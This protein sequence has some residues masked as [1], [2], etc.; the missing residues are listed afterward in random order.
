[1]LRLPCAPNAFAA[2]LAGVTGDASAADRQGLA[3]GPCEVS[4]PYTGGLSSRL[5][6]S[7]S[8]FFCVFFSHLKHTH[9]IS[10]RQCTPDR[11]RPAAAAA[12]AEGHFTGFLPRLLSCTH[13]GVHL[14]ALSAR[15]ELAQEHPPTSTL[16]CRRPAFA[17]SSLTMMSTMKSSYSTASQPPPRRCRCALLRAPLFERAHRRRAGENGCRKVLTASLRAALRPL[18]SGTV[19]PRSATATT[20]ARRRRGKDPLRGWGRARTHTHAPG[21]VLVAPLP[22]CLHRTL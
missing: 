22:P 14:T 1:M 2:L 18:P 20:R 19:P 3:A 12:A 9:T 11:P 16:A 10:Y 15:A 8:V 6:S 13:I 17:P 5:D 21:L 7:C 4:H